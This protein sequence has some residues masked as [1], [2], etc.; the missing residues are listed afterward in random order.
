MSRALD[1][2]VVHAETIEEAL[3]WAGKLQPNVI[4]LDTILPDGI[5]WEAIPRFRDASPNSEIVIVTAHG[6][7]TDAIRA[8]GEFR[9]KAYI[10]KRDGVDA[11]R[12]E[13]REAFMASLVGAVRRW[14]PAA[15]RHPALPRHRRAS[16]RHLA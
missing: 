13:V 15:L 6:T 7:L 8:V 9:A 10:E 11:I 14:S 4:L 3:V 16:L 5:G 12:N 1:G 2:Q